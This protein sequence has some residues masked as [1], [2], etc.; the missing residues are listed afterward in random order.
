MCAVRASSSSPI[1]LA[2]GESKSALG[3]STRSTLSPNV[4]NDKLRLNVP[5]A[6]GAPPFHPGDFRLPP[7]GGFFVC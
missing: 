3:R 7:S 2:V 5:A 4:R 6:C 1:L